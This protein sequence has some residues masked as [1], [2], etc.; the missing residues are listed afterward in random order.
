MK[1]IVG[2][3]VAVYFLGAVSLYALQ[4][5]MLYAQTAEYS[6]DLNEIALNS[7]GET[8]KILELNSGKDNAIIYFGGNAEPVVFNEEPFLD[9]FTNHTVYLV[10]YRGYGGS[11]GTPTEQGLLADAL[12]IYDKL[13]IYHDSISVISLAKKCC[14]FSVGYTI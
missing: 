5:E 3:I 11:S 12:A 6:T 9:T 10:N 7:S 13:I 8:L 1:I 4:R 14:V 2:I